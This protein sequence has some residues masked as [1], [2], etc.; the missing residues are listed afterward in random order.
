MGN[1]VSV[2]R[3]FGVSVGRGV[4][5]GLGTGVSVGEATGM[6]VDEGVA[7]TELETSAV[8]I[9]VEAT[10]ACVSVAAG[11]TEPPVASSPPQARKPK[12]PH[13]TGQRPI[14]K[15]SIQL[16]FCNPLPVI[17]CAK[18]SVQISKYKTLVKV[19]ASGMVPRFASGQAQGNPGY[20]CSNP[21]ERSSPRCYNPIR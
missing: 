10:G 5:V 6:A 14:S 13:Q 3:G 16:P 12:P 20:D 4:L 17:L 21:V 2:G 15:S 8:G 7:G 18:A 11:A 19:D 9:G 1:G